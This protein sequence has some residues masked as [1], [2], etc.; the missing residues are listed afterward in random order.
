ML[1]C[2]AYGIDYPAALDLDEQEAHNYT[3]CQNF[4]QESVWCKFWTYNTV[5]KN[6]IIKATKNTPTNV[7]YAVSGPKVC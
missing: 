6:C 2:Y 3:H 5:T 7:S 1:G 4:C